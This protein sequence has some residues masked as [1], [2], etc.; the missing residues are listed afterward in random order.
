VASGEIPG[1]S[2]G[3]ETF[4]T[5]EGVTCDVCHTVTKVTPVRL[6]GG[7]NA[8]LVLEDGET[9]YGPIADPVDE[10]SH[11]SAYLEIY[12]RAEF[13]SACHTLLHP[14][15]GL[16]IE[17]TYEEW[18]HSPFAK[19]G[20]QCQDCH[21]RTVKQ[22]TEVAR[23]MEPV[24]TP[25]RT[26]EEGDP[27][28]N[29]HAHLFVG[30]NS[31]AGLTGSSERHAEMARQRLRSA[32]RLALRL[33]ETARPGGTPEVVVE[34][35]NVGAGHSIP[36]SITELRQ[37]WIDLQVRDAG[38]QEIFRSGAVADNGQVD[39]SAVLYHSVLAD[40]QGEITYL[41]WRAAKI[42]REKL[43]PA[44]K[45]LSERYKVPVPAAT[46]G[47]L[48]V[49]ARLRY[50]SAPQEVMDELF[51]KGRFD[52]EIVDMAVTEGLLRLNG[53]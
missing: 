9:R 12:S 38:G 47:P 20:I 52:L 39:P 42:I 13:C 18:K 23:T 44:G 10:A 34:V 21:L 1:R 7:A 41:P 8:S 19:A 3:E 30:G 5:D 40:E 2:G 24:Q 49:Q 36:T 51:G 45:T 31:N 16:V 32:A 53:P 46:K 29:V 27:R 26:Y 28:P 43:I 22:A 17:N 15:N 50:R 4:L 48:R 14:H 33:P 6:G 25:G 11:D 37:V 35:S